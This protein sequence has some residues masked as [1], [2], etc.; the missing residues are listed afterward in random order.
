MCYI[1]IIQ[2]GCMAN[3]YEDYAERFCVHVIYN[4]DIQE[5]VSTFIKNRFPTFDPDAFRRAIVS[6][7]RKRKWM[8][9]NLGLHQGYITRACIQFGKAFPGHRLDVQVDTEPEIDPDEETAA[10]GACAQDN[11][12]MPRGPNML[13]A[14]AEGFLQRVTRLR[15]R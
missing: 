15:V 3:L 12:D 13:R 4:D 11:S 9:S 14:F 6:E 10:T 8:N 7:M 5:W 2:L 1:N